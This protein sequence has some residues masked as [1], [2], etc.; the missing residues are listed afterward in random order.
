MQGERHGTGDKRTCHA[1][2]KQ[3]TVAEQHAVNER[4]ANASNKLGDKIAGALAL[5]LLVAEFKP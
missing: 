3:F 2:S 5:F 4:L 1:G